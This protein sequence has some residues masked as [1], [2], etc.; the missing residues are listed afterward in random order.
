MAIHWR[1]YLILLVFCCHILHDQV[2]AQEKPVWSEN[3]EHFDPSRTI[4][5]K[6]GQALNL[7]RTASKRTPLSFAL[8][9]STFGNSFSLTCWVKGEP[10]FERYSIIDLLFTYP[11][12]TTASWS[13]QKQVNQS[14]A[15]KYQQ[16][17]KEL[18]YEGSHKSQPIH[19]DWNLLAMLVN[20]N[21]EEVTLYY[22]QQQVAIYSLEGVLKKGTVQQVQLTIA[23]ET[24]GELSEWESFN[25]QIDE[26]N[27]YSGL[28][29]K[30]AIQAYYEKHRQGYLKKE[31]ITPT[32]TLRIMSFNIWH[33]GNETGK[34]FG[35]ERIAQLIKDAK[36]DIV[37]MQETYGSGAKIAAEL[38]YY[39]YLRS[40]NISILSRYP[41]IETLAAY[42]PFNNGNAYIQLGRDTIA[43]ACVW[44][45][46]PIDYWANIEN[47]KKMDIQEWQKLQLGNTNSMRGIIQ[48]LKSPLERSEDIPVF[49]CGDF[50]S[51]SHLD[52]VEA[53]RYRNGGYNMPFPTS[54]YLDSLGFRDTYRERYPDP[55]KNPGTTWSPIHPKVHQ[56]RIDYIYLKNKR[57]QLIDSRIIDAGKEKYPS[58]HA[59][60]MSTFLFPQK[61]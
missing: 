16:G 41:I 38:G 47:N 12:S 39:F 34:A 5:G 18:L 17:E 31:A 36:A 46:Y 9:S 26:V 30:E 11:D 33:G 10:D 53:T 14:W 25:G 20:L 50:N 1:S 21:K 2:L 61:P 44:L 49:I 52:Y 56:D 42:K 28:L 37:A 45:N 58:D 40:T 4:P 48:A 55:V 54:L 3:F 7:T 19:K 51:G 27:I 13:I 43:V 24:R 22:N 60:V 35:Y 29:S 57:L 59:A 8:P 32:D 23:G 6:V 15:W